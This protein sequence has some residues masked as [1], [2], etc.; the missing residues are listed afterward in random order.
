M[1]RVALK[2]LAGRKLR[3]LLTA[4]AI[5]L[6]VAMVSGTFILTDTIQKGFDT[7]SQRSYEGTDAVITGKVAFASGD[8]ESSAA[9]FPA[10]VLTRV[11]RLPE[12]ASATGLIEDEAGLVGRD[13]KTIGGGATPRLAFSV[14][15]EADQRFNPLELAAGSWPSGRNAIAIDRTT[16]EKEGFEVGD[17]IRVAAR[18]PVRSFEISGLAEFE[19]VSI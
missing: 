13:G 8:D 10:D 1:K 5:V 12:V 9:S 14:D 7:I 19:D 11:E 6:G 18:G 17:T 4:L 2:G 16:A 15:S 3:S